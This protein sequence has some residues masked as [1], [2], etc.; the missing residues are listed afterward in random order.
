ML[1]VTVSGDIVTDNIIAVINEYYSN[2]IVKDVIWDY[3]NGSLLS[4]SQ[5]DFN[6]IIAAIKNSLASGARVNG[7]TA[8]VGDR[9]VEYGILRMF[10]VYGETEG[11]TIPCSVFRTTEEARRWLE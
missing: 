1:I 7:K 10:T 6:R 9:T 4:A 8:Y 3:T 11:I 2:G 5:K